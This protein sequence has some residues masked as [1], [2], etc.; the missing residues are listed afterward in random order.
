METKHREEPSIVLDL[1]PSISANTRIHQAVP[2]LGSLRPWLAASQDGRDLQR[3]QWCESWSNM[4]GYKLYKVGTWLAK[5]G[6]FKTSVTASYGTWNATACSPTYN[7]EAATGY[8]TNEAKQKGAVRTTAKTCSCGPIP[9]THSCLH[10]INELFTWPGS[11]APVAPIN[12]QTSL[13][14]FFFG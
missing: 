2:G 9:C 4:A 6:W 8:Q 7:R 3:I 13:C 10:P 5:L 1:A 14:C 12:D 11:P